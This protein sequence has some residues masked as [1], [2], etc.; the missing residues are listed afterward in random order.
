MS[1]G[2]CWEEREEG[3]ERMIVEEGGERGQ[4]EMRDMWNGLVV[5]TWPGMFLET[6]TWAWR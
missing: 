5:F 1:R 6:Q 4:V 2:R 3:E